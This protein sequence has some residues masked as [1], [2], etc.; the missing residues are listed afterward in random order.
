MSKKATRKA[1]IRRRRLRRQKLEL[2]R[3]R[4]RG[5]DNEAKK[6]KISEDVIKI[7]PRLTRERFERDQKQTGGT[8]TLS[9]RG[10]VFV[11]AR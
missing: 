10:N 9:E 5:A 4:M 11:Q 2:L 8:P 7:A 6:A 1:E 3:A